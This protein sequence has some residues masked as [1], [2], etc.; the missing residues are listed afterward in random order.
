MKLT[1]D[2]LAKF[3]SLVGKRGPDE[4]WPW[5]GGKSMGYGAMRIG[6]DK[7]KKRAHVISLSL[8]LGRNLCKGEQAR[9]TCDSPPCCNPKHLVPGTMA[10]NMTDMRSRGREARSALTKLQERQV[11]NLY[12]NKRL[13]QYE[14]AKMFKCSQPRVSQLLRSKLCQ[15]LL[16]KLRYRSARRS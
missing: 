16:E 9:H 8:K 10:D 1:P 4:C 12:A 3:W 11:V 5:L 7:R 6:P 13:S 14:L 15:S 2:E